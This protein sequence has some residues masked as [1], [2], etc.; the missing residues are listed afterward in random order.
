MSFIKSKLPSSVIH[1]LEIKK[2]ID[3]KWQVLLLTELLKEY[4]LACEKVKTDSDK[5]FCQNQ[6]LK[7][8]LNTLT[9]PKKSFRSR[10][11]EFID[12]LMRLLQLRKNK[13]VHLE[14]T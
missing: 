1:H 13:R 2:G 7:S 12:S 5:A 4:V 9:G 10:N 14:Q 3:K 11:K 8:D 6:D